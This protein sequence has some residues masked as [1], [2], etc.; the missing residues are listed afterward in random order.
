MDGSKASPTM[1]L[2]LGIDETT[3]EEYAS[4]SR[5]LQEFTNIA[6]IEKA[7]IIPGSGTISHF[8]NT[9]LF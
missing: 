1:E 3:E 4:Q 9:S 6:S 7:W 5:L 2:P 8:L